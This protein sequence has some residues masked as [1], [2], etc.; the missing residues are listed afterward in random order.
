MGCTTRYSNTSALRTI[1]EQKSIL[2]GAQSLPGAGHLAERCYTSR[3][4]KGQMIDPANCKHAR[5]QLVAKDQD[6]EYLECL[7]C[8]AILEAGE[9]DG[10]SDFNESLSDA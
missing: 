7:D 8:G 1:E 4:E 9:L 6:A 2:A 10:P 3:R 5:T